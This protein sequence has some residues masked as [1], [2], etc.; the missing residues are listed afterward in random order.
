MAK[1]EKENMLDNIIRRYGF[2]AYETIKF[3]RL[4][5]DDDIDTDYIEWVYKKYMK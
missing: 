4:I 5:E 1:T 2:E 3:A